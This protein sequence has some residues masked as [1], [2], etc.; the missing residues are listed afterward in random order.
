MTPQEVEA[1]VALWR[2][3]PTAQRPELKQDEGL[4]CLVGIGEI[5]LVTSDEAQDLIVGHLRKWMEKRCDD[6]SIRRHKGIGYIVAWDL[7]GQDQPHGGVCT[8]SLI[9]SMTAAVMS[10]AATEAGR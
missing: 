1:V 4:F 3:V 6:F 7:A 10:V 8:D 2:E 5:T 9:I